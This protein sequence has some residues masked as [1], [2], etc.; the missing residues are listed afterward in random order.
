MGLAVVWVLHSDASLQEILTAAPQN[1]LLTVGLL[2]L[3][4]VLKSLSI[5]SRC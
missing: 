5:F 4:Y 3:F 1:P 2:L